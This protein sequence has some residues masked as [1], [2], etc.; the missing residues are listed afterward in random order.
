MRI[1][2]HGGNIVTV[3]GTGNHGFSGDGGQATQAMIDE[4]FALAFDRRGDLFIADSKNARVRRV[5]LDGTIS[6]VAGDGDPRVLSAP[7]A[8]AIDA[9]DVL[10]I[11]DPLNHRV[12]KLPLR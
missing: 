8:I 9:N 10:F 4:P 5:A 3:A 11:A 1:I 12:L 2:D 6:T 7:S